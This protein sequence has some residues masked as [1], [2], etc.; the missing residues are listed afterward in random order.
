MYIIS[1]MKDKKRSSPFV[2]ILLLSLFYI[3]VVIALVFFTYTL[4]KNKN[5]SKLTLPTLKRI[6]LPKGTVLLLKSVPSSR[7][8]A[9]RC[10]IKTGSVYEGKWLGSGISHLV[11]H[12]LFKGTDIYSMSQISQAFRD[13]GG[14]HN[15]WTSFEKTVFYVTVPSENAATAMKILANAV[16]FSSF[17]QEELEKEKKVVFNEILMNQ[18]NIDRFFS[19]LIFKTFFSTHPYRYPVIGEA[20]LMLSL[21]RE[22]LIQYHKERYRPS[23]LIFAVAGSFDEKTVID[24]LNSELE[25]VKEVPYSEPVIR[26]ETPKISGLYREVIRPDAE[27][28]R[29]ALVWNGVPVKHKDMPALDLISVILGEG[30][31]SVLYK[32][33]KDEKK[34]VKDISAF[35]YNLGDAGIVGIE[36]ILE[37]KNFLQTTNAIFSLLK[38]KNFLNTFELKRAKN[39]ILSQSISSLQTMEGITSELTTDEA[40]LGD[41]E[42]SERYREII[43]SISVSEIKKVFEKYFNKNLCSV[44]AVRTPQTY[45][46]ISSNFYTNKGFKIEKK[47]LRNGL[48][49][50]YVHRPEIPLVNLKFLIKGGLLLDEKPGL[51]RFVN[52]SLAGGSRKFPG[53][54]AFEKIESIGGSLSFFAGNNSASVTVESLSEYLNLAVNI[55]YD[56]VRFPLFSEEKVELVRQDLISE[57]K[58]RKENLFNEG[59]DLLKELV[60]TNHPYRYPNCGTLSSISNIKISDLKKFHKRYYVADRSVLVVTGR[61]SK[62]DKN[63]IE[64]VF[65]NIPKR[66]VKDILWTDRRS[67]S[68]KL[69]VR[70][71]TDKKRSLVLMAWSMPSVTNSNRWKIELL[72]SLLSG[73]GGRLFIRLRDI[74]HLGYSVGSIPFFFLDDGIFVF[75]ATTDSSKLN[76][77]EKS[78]IRE[79]HNLFSSDPP[80]YSETLSSIKDMLGEKMMNEQSF[81]S[82][83]LEVGLFELFYNRAEYY[84]KIPELIQ[85]LTSQDLKQ[86][87]EYIFSRPHYTVV[88]RG[89]Q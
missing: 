83:G 53:S 28:T 77:A 13:I 47:V 64:N 8:T 40:D 44:I 9:L 85:S 70:K 75:Y 69:E 29:L 51:N 89:T 39:I 76:Q 35:S 73:L 74:E 7:V 5:E 6:E 42:F 26:P 36:A 63:F 46:T 79:A 78:F 25:K 22:D 84:L 48:R 19:T 49:V 72:N 61:I 41:P 38:N 67:F 66:K 12:M 3:L 86:I 18:D 81:D 21:N 55:L 71:N 27:L 88:L 16:L 15:A 62:K 54:S 37:D 59:L 43:R 52:E 45:K 56:T 1:M 57:A 87:A 2:S 20:S 33:I 24:A 10:L 17:P 23:N 31:A 80:T 14:Q 50:V 60:Y 82:L 68:N 58:S 30:R 32:K 11:E 65:C 4:K 34:L